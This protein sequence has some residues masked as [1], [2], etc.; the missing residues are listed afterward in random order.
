[1]FV[2]ID[3]KAKYKAVLAAG[4]VQESSRRME[5]LLLV[6]TDKAVLRV[7]QSKSGWRL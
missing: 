3:D 6:E 7:N 2:W 5:P 1:M 4:L